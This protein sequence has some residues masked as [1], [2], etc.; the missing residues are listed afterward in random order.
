[1]NANGFPIGPD[2]ARVVLLPF[3]PAAELRSNAQG[4][5][6]RVSQILDRIVM[7]DP[8]AA[9]SQLAEVTGNFGDRHRDLAGRFEARAVQLGFGALTTAQRQLAGAYF[10]MEY[11]FEAAASFNP[12]M[13]AH[14]D[15][16]GVPSG[17][18]RVILS[19]RAVGEGHISSLIFRS[20]MV[21]ADGQVTLDPAARLAC[22]PQQLSREAED[23]FDS[24]EI[25]F[26]PRHDI[27][28]RVIF[29]VTEAQSN[30]IEDARFVAF[31]D[32][33][34]RR[35]YATYTAYNGRGIRSELIETTDFVT[36]RMTSLRGTAARNKGMALFPR[37]VGGRYA[38]I[39]REDAENLYFVTS[40]DLRGWD[41]GILILKPKHAWEFIQIGNCGSPIELDEGWLLFMHGVGPVRSYAIGAVLLDKTDPSRVL[42]RSREPLLRPLAAERG[43]YVPNVVYSCGGLRHGDRII[44]PYGVS[45]MFAH[46]TTMQTDALLRTLEPV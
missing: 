24:V 11:S 3:T 27:S 14:P 18:L 39:S 22:L 28:E 19:L 1:M 12:S 26:D 31:E 23:G 15:Q 44:L 41:D 35:Y 5:D 20:G 32:G 30:G 2:P 10:L 42:A 6:T 43:G 16:S 13:V 38:M 37:R 17:G 45:D 29:P 8:E 9:A 40:D 4:R 36:F 21:T 7:L 33:D 46:V 25:G 34:V